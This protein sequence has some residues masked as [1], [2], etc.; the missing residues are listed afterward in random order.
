MHITFVRS[1]AILTPSWVSVY[2]QRLMKIY[3]C[4]YICRIRAVQ[5]HVTCS[6]ESLFHVRRESTFFTLF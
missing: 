5:L 4:Y 6:S 1:P 3:V 2:Y